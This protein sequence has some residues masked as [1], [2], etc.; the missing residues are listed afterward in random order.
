M[1]SELSTRAYKQTARAKAAEETGQRIAEAFHDLLESG[2]FDEIRL[3]DVASKAGVSVQTVIRR[4]GGKE[5]LLQLHAEQMHRLILTERRLPIGDAVEAIRAIIAE[6]ELRG[7]MVMRLLAQEDRFPQLMGV[8]ERGREVHRE[9]VGSVFEPWL[10]ELDGNARRDTHDRLVI[11]LDLYIWK[12]L[13]KDMR[14]SRECLQ[15]VMLEMAADAL[16]ITAEELEAGRV[17]SM[18]DTDG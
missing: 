4:F 17:A 13:R 14:R 6:Y 10:R 3:E 12:L 15:R 7:D 11:A 1:N 5:G 16:G 18:E 2:W 8:A 9:W